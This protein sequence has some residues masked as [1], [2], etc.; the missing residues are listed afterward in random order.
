MLRFFDPH[1]D[2]LRTWPGPR[3]N[4]PLSPTINYLSLPPQLASTNG[5]VVAE[6]EHGIRHR[7]ITGTLCSEHLFRMRAHEQLVFTS[8]MLEVSLGVWRL[9]EVEQIER[10]GE[11]DAHASSSSK[12]RYL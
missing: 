5:G 1:L 10:G 12:Y 8:R 6:E 3:R 7:V 4:G 2:G 11:I 9:I